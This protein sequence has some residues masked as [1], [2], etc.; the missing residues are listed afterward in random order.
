MLTSF[1]AE[2]VSILNGGYDKWSTEQQPVETEVQTPT[3]ATDDEGFDWKLD[4]SNIASLEDVHRTSF[5]ILNGESKSP[6]ILDSRGQ[7]NFEKG[8]PEGAICVPTPGLFNEDK[9][10]KSDEELRAQFTAAGIK[11]DTDVTFTC[12]AG[13]FA[14]TGAFVYEKLGYTGKAT[15]YDGSW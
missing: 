2:N 15:M 12:G 9:T 7:E 1:G 6:I 8:S 5:S 4:E 10:L 3:P 11:E 14:C 13:I